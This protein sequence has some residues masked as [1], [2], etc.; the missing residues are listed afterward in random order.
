[1]FQY[2]ILT[3]LNITLFFKNDFRN[4][5]DLT[6][7]K[8]IINNIKNIRSQKKNFFHLTKRE[9][10]RLFSFTRSRF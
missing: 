7:S 2:L 5:N 4:A 3:K 8:S 9:K 10:T 1:M 6:I